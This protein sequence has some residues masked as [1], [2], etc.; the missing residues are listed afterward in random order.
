MS[1]RYILDAAG[2]PVHEPDLNTWGSWFETAERHVAKDQ[3]GDVCVST[4]FLALD[5][6]FGGGGDPVLWETMIFQ[7]PH[8]GYQERYTS[9]AAAEAGHAAAVKLVRAA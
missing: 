3:I 9:R 2:Q 4:V 5:H 7:G 1:D 6:R 8:D